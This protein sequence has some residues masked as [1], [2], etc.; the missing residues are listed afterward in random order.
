LDW[1]RKDEESGNQQCDTAN[2]SAHP[3]QALWT[4][5]L[6]DFKKHEGNIILSVAV[7]PG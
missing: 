2:P 4:R 5:K 1:C 6:Q 3:Q 7:A